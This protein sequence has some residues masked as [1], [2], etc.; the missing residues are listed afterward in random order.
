MQLASVP[1][2]L[3]C[4]ADGPQDVVLDVVQGRRSFNLPAPSRSSFFRSP[5]RRLSLYRCLVQSFASGYPTMETKSE[6]ID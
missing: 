2:L 5:I 4:S 3:T 1:K 6:Q